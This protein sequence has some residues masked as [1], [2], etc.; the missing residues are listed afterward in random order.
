MTSRYYD[1]KTNIADYM[2]VD[3]ISLMYTYICVKVMK[4]R[5]LSFSALVHRIY[6]SVE[7]FKAS[8][9]RLMQLLANANLL[10]CNFTICVITSLTCVQTAVC[11]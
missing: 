5:K 9:V 2:Y 3:E 7:K 1:G 6:L 4:E 11:I 10:R 8:V